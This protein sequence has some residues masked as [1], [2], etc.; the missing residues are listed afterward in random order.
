MGQPGYD[1]LFTVCPVFDSL[2]SKFEKYTHQR[3]NSLSTRQSVHVFCVYMKGKPYKYGIEIFHLSE[4][5]N[6]YVHNI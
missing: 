4:V 1:P 6:G 5:E 2:T 3:M